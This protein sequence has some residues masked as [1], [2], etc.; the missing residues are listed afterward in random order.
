MMLID[1]LHG[2]ALYMV[3]GAEKQLVLVG[4]QIVEHS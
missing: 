1:A 4:S 2:V 3:I